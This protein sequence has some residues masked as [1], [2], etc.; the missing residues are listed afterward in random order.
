MMELL[1]SLLALEIHCYSTQGQGHL[2]W[3]YDQIFTP[4]FF[5]CITKSSMKE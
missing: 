5:E 4:C 1:I 2:K 3:F